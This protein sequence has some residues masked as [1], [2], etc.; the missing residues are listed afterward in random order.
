VNSSPR[1]YL[2]FVFGAL[3]AA[4]MS[5]YANSNGPVDTN[6]GVRTVEIALACNAQTVREAKAVHDWDMRFFAGPSTRE[7]VDRKAVISITPR[8]VTRRRDKWSQSDSV[9]IEMS[10]SDGAALE[11]LT[12]DALKGG[13][14]REFVLVN[15]KIVLSA[16]VSAPFSGTEFWI[17]PSSDDYAKGIFS[18]IT[19]GPARW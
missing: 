11:K 15:G 2:R 10:A 8:N 17:D 6:G 7:C 19:G 9:V 1:K 3:C 4:S 14:R 16:F 13:M 5:S 12:D 18:L